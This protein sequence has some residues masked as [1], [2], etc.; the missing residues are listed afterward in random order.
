MCECGG[1]HG[2]PCFLAH[3]EKVYQRW[4]DANKEK[5]VDF[6]KKKAEEKK[7]EE[8]KE[9]ACCAMNRSIKDT[10]FFFDTA[11]SLHYTYFK[12]WYIDE[13]T[14]LNDPVEV[15]TCDG[16]TVYVTH[17]G[18]IK[19][20]V[21]IINDKGH[22]EEVSLTI[23]DIYFCPE[24]NTNLLLLGIF[25]RNGL[26][27]GASKKRLQSPTMRAISSWKVCWWIPCSNSV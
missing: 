14:M 7:E 26:S 13:P 3:P 24:M 4:R 5:I 23:K 11:A 10:G 18:L 9:K 19:L 1:T 12:T 20:D 17:I 15:E 21:L 27:F 6:K 22:D 25:V 16:G 2:P 8:K